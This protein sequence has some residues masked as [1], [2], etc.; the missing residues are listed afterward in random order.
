MNKNIKLTKKINSFLIYIIFLFFFINYVLIS[1][2]NVYQ[3]DDLTF[4]ADVNKEGILRLWWIYFHW[5]ETNLNSIIMFAMTKFVRFIPPFAYNILIFTTNILSFNFFLNTLSNKYELKLSTIKCF[6]ISIFIIGVTYFSC[7]AQGNVTYWVVG[8]I[9][10]CLFLS[11]LFL[12]ISFWMKNKIISASFFLFMFAHTRI[13]Y[14][15]IFIGLFFSYFIYKLFSNSD[16]KKKIELK[17]LL[18]FIAFLFGLISYLMIPGNYKRAELYNSTNESTISIFNLSYLV[19]MAAKDSVF[20]F[21]SNWKQ[22]IILPIGIL[23]SIL[24]KDSKIETELTKPRLLWFAFSLII[25][26]IGQAL[27]LLISIKTTNYSP[28]IYFFFEFLFFIF[29]F[30]IGLKIGVKINKFISDYFSNIIIYITSIFLLSLFIYDLNN[31]IRKVRK[32]NRAYNKRIEMLLDYKNKKRTEPVFLDPLPESGSLSFMEIKPLKP[33]QNTAS[34][35]EAYIQY[36][37]LPYR[38][39]IKEK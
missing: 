8:Q 32:F 27:V 9:V 35:I 12:G 23:F 29:L 37:Q 17:E 13:N 22:I 4:Y 33:G 5:W 31:N 26:F 2:Y 16:T 6:L 30:L 20:S 36:Y 15:A 14:D 18:P 24:Y 38:I 7:S 19:L 10:Y 25:A 21:I 28:R 11:Y 3:N 34:D 39:Y 1:F